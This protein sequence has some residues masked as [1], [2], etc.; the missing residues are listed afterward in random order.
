MSPSGLGRV[1]GDDVQRYYV[2][3]DGGRDRLD[4]EEDESW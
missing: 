1:D 3:G 2:A 4:V